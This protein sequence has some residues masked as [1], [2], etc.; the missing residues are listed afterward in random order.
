[1]LGSILGEMTPPWVF[2]L[3]GAVLVFCVVGIGIVTWQTY[4]KKWQSYQHNQGQRIIETAERADNWDKAQ[5]MRSAA[6]RL[7]AFWRTPLGQHINKTPCLANDSVRIMPIGEKYT[8]PSSVAG[9]ATWQISK[10]HA[11]HVHMIFPRPLWRVCVS[12]M[13]DHRI[14][15]MKLARL[16]ERAI[17]HCRS[18]RRKRGAKATIRKS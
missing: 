1:M 15:P 6:D 18:R 5:D 12:W 7:N 4:R 8:Q 14:L 16:L 2:Y 11:V 17:I 10:S 13:V 3:S 9:L